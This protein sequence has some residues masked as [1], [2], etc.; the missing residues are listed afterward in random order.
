MTG[1]R[2]LDVVIAYAGAVLM[3]SLVLIAVSCLVLMTVIA[4]GR[5]QGKMAQMAAA[6]RR[7]SPVDAPLARNRTRRLRMVLPL[8]V[9]LNLVSLGILLS[10]GG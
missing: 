2:W 1:Y 4:R 5:H 7:F 8:L 10:R 3:T 9:L 6:Y